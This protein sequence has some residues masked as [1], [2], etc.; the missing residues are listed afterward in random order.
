VER[1]LRLAMS[2]EEASGL[3]HSAELLRTTIATLGLDPR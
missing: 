3:R 1:T 2:A